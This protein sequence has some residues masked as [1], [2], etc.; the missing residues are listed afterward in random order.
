MK[1]LLNLVLIISLSSCASLSIPTLTDVNSKMIAPGNGVLALTLNTVQR[2]NHI[3]IDSS[4][5]G[6]NFVIKWPPIGENIFLYEVKA[7]E[8]C[9]ERL[10]FNTFTVS[11]KDAYSHSSKGICTV[12]EEG[13]LA[14]SG[15][16]FLGPNTT[17]YNYYSSFVQKLNR[18]YPNT[19]KEFIGESCEKK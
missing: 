18:E 8:Y 6:H 4:N 12:V 7:G 15:H 9:L 14:Y 17:T 2:I 1:N 19:C 3:S 16:I 13:A 11:F 5:P 10:T